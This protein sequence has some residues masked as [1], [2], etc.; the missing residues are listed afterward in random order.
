MLVADLELG[1]GSVPTLGN[2]ALGASRV[3][4]LHQESSSEEQIRDRIAALLA[5]R[6]LRRRRV[7][8]P[9]FCSGLL[10]TAAGLIRLGL[11]GALPFYTLWA[12]APLASG[13]CILTL[14]I[15]DHDRAFVTILIC[16]IIGVLCFVAAE[17]VRRA[18]RHGV[19]PVS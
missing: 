2:M 9:I 7:Q 8:L 10:L 15:L 3:P 13:L 17:D 12:Y 18:A 11:G 19:W 6:R 14:S 1:R 16:A 4:T 5:M